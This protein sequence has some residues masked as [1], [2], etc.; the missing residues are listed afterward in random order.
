MSFEGSSATVFS[1]NIARYDGGAVFSY[2]DVVYSDNS[3]VIFTNNNA[4]HGA[5]VY[6]R[7]SKVI[8]SSTI[9]I[10]DHL[11]KWCNNTCLPYRGYP[12]GIRDVITID[13]NGVV[14]CTDQKAFICLSTNCYCNKLE[15][16]L[17]DLQN[18]TIVNITDNVTLSSV[19]DL[20]DLENISIIGHNNITVICGIDGGGL[21]LCSCDNLI[22]KGFTWIGCGIINHTYYHRPVLEFCDSSGITIQNCTF[23]YSIEQV[24]SLHR[25]DS[26]V[27]IDHCDFM[28]NNLHGDYRAVIDCYNVL[29]ININNCNFSY[30]GDSGSI[31]DFS[32]SLD[33]SFTNIYLTNSNYQNN[34]GTSIYL[35]GDNLILHINGEILFNGNTAEFGAGVYICCNASVIFDRNSNVQFVY[36]TASYDG[37]AI[38]ADQ[39]SSVIFD[40]NSNVQFVSNTASYDGAAINVEEYS[41]V[42]FD[43]YSNVLFVS[44]TASYDGAAIYAVEYSSVIFDRNSNVQFVSNTASDSGAAICVSQYSSVTFEQ[45]S[46]ATFS[47]NK[48][49]SESDTVFGAAIYLYRYSSVTFEQNSVVT[50]ILLITKP[51]WV[52]F[53]LRTTLM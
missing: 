7:N 29:T 22:V 38:Y 50:L 33:T 6:S 18:N 15:Y 43:R 10:N 21:Y 8:E 27:N 37:A 48:A 40:R 12:Y 39:Y 47:D 49:T 28:N 32:S 2:S 36:N 46:V 31:L 41:S 20:S 44:N 25:I 26:Y 35:S 45:S 1:N 16:L 19:I 9:F 23:R 42:I 34:K 13:S 3:T 53:T 14:W 17:D 5:M 30:N 52:L 51:L 4:R 24:I 11:V